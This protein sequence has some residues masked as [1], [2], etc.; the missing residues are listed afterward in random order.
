MRLTSALMYLAMAFVFAFSFAG[1]ASAQV[2]PTGT[3]V[4]TVT[5]PSVAT[6]PGATVTAKG[7]STGATVTATSG[8]PVRFDM[9]PITKPPPHPDVGVPL[10]PRLYPLLHQHP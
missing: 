5:D 6:I 7:A 8:P 4:G 3:L 1:V 2:S 10:A 9:V